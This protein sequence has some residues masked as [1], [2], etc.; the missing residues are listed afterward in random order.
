MDLINRD[1]V[2]K[3]LNKH[4]YSKE[5]CSEHGIDYSINMNMARIVVGD[6]QPVDAKPVIHAWWIEHSHERGENWEDSMYECSEC[7]SWVDDDSNYCPNCGALM[8]GKEQT[9]E[10]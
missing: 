9:D 8:H 6:L 7:H 4:Q 1:D 5:F 10:L 3:A 2:I